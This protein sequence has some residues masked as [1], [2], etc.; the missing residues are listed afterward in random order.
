MIFLE[1]KKKKKKKLLKMKKKTLKMDSPKKSQ[2]NC[3]DIS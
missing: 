1:K 3:Q 2:K